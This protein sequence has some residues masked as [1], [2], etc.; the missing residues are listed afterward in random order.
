MTLTNEVFEDRKT[1]IEFYYSVM[2]EMDD[3][4]KT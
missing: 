4:S 3:E 1:E 2:V